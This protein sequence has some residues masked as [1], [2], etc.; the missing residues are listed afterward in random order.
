MKRRDDINPK[1]DKG[2]PHGYWVS[3]WGDNNLD[4]IRTYEN[5]F[6]VG[7]WKEYDFYGE[8]LMI[9]FNIL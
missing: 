9:G 3:Y 4:F 5:G 8:L 7:C 2:Q 1:N 6:I